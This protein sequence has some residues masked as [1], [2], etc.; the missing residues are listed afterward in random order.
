MTSLQ[1]EIIL[2]AILTAITCALPGVFLVL[3]SVAMMSDAISHAILLG[4]VIMFLWV[5]KLES[6]LLLVGAALTGVLTVLCTEKIIKSNRL[7]SDAA[8]GLIFP[9]FFSIGVIL[10]SQYARNV[11]LDIDMVLLGEI[12]FAPFNR[13][14]INGIDC[15]PYA[16]WI[17]G[18]SLLLNGL[19]IFLFYKELLITTFDTTLSIMMNFSPVVI[20]Y[21]LM[22][23]TSVTAVAVFDI[24][25][26]IMVVALMITPAATAYLLTCHVYS[27]IFVS[28]I[29]AC[30]SAICGC[31]CASYY[32]ISIAGS[33]A[34]MTGLFFM[35]VLILRTYIKG[36][37]CE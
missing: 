4:I 11:H 5:K 1:L 14:F 16:L 23:I 36:F 13:L 3:R 28:I 17:V 8:I 33:I 19:F 20:Y 6:P 2:I 37:F 31:I 7:K 18:G 34:S 29:I 22:I 21:S 26:S 35:S 12:A 27:M 25:G 30:L 32:D 15:G 24:V 9:L 10:V